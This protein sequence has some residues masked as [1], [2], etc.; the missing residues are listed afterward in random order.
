MASEKGQ[1]GGKSSSS[2]RVTSPSQTIP[3]E[4]ELIVIARQEAN[5]RATPEALKAAPGFQVEPL[6]NSLA[7]QGWFSSRCLV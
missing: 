2:R 1:P 6:A 3:H 5:L 4:R 7:S